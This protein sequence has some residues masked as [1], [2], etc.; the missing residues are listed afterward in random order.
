MSNSNRNSAP[1]SNVIMNDYAHVHDDRVVGSSRNRGRTEASRSASLISCHYW[2]PL[3]TIILLSAAK[4]GRQLQ[5]T[6]RRR[7]ANNLL[8]AAFLRA[9]HVGLAFYKWQHNLANICGCC[10]LRPGATQ[11]PIVAVRHRKG[12]RRKEKSKI[13]GTIRLGNWPRMCGV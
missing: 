9:G 2:Q 11:A 12:T 13:C 10:G 7:D 4:Y 8:G 6:S 5:R 1:S 3:T